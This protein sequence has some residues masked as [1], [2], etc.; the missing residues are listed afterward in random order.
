MVQPAPPALE[1][2][3][4]PGGPEYWKY[5]PRMAYVLSTLALVVGLVHVWRTMREDDRCMRLTLLRQARLMAAAIQ[6]DDLKKLQG[7][8][9]DLAEPQYHRLKRHIELLQRTQPD[10]HYIY[11]VGHRNN[12]QIFFFL[13]NA[14]AD[15]DDFI[16]PGTLYDEASVNFRLAVTTGKEI[17]EGPLADQWGNWISAVAPI[18]DHSTGRPTAALGVDIDASRW[19][20]QLLHQAMPRAAAVIVIWLFA[21]AAIAM[22]HHRYRQNPH[23]ADQSPT[24]ITALIAILGI[25]IT[26][27]ACRRTYEK[28][29]QE[30]ADA[31][32]RLA[33]SQTGVTAR[34]FHAI[35][36]T[37]LAGLAHFFASRPDIRKDEFNSYI[38][39]LEGKP[40]VSLWGWSEP[41]PANEREAFAT[42]AKQRGIN[43]ITIWEPGPNREIRPAQKR[44]TFYPVL[45]Y[46]PENGNEYILGADLSSET[47][48]LRAITDATRSRLPTAT[49][50]VG[51][52]FNDRSKG[53]LIFYPVFTPGTTSALRGVAFASINFA[54]LVNRE[55]RR[56]EM[57]HLSLHALN[58]DAIPE[59]LCESGKDPN[60]PDRH[61]LSRPFFA[62]GQV[63]LLNSHPNLSFYQAHPFQR[64]RSILLTGLAL[65]LAIATICNLLLKRRA[66]LIADMHAHT[67][68]LSET[69]LL[70]NQ[71]AEQSRTVQWRC[72]PDGR[73]SEVNPV[74][75]RVFGYSPEQLVGKMS[76]FDLNPEA[77]R[78]TF[79]P[80]MQ[81]VLQQRE[82][83]I[84]I[85]KSVQIADGSVIKVSSSGTPII[86]EDGQLT[87]F[88]GW[89]RDVTDREELA[90]KLLQSQRAAEAANQAKSRFIT[91][92][93][94]EIRT[95]INGVIGFSDLLRST[96][97]NN[98]QR[99]YVDVIGSSSCQLLGLVNELLDYAQLD[100]GG[101]KIVHHD[102][103]LRIT[104]EDLCCQLAVNAHQKNLELLCVIPP[105]LSLLLHGDELHLQQAILCLLDNAVKFTTE[106]EVV[107][108]V[109][110]DKEDDKHVL[111]RFTVSDSGIGIS[112]ALQ[113]N[114]FDSF[115]QA[116]ESIKRRHGGAGL[117]LAIAKHLIEQMGGALTITSET[118][119]GSVFSFAIP[120]SKQGGGRPKLHPPPP[121]LVHAP[122]LVVDDN[123][124]ACQYLQD[125]LAYKALQPHGSSE[126]ASAMSMLQ[127]ARDARRPFSLFFLDLTMPGVDVDCAAALRQAAG[128]STI[129]VGMLPL[130]RRQSHD[131]LLLKHFPNIITKPIRQKDLW[132]GLH[133]AVH[134]T[135]RPPAAD[136]QQAPDSTGQ[137][138]D[139]A[140]PLW[141][142]A[143]DTP[144]P[145]ATILLVEDHPVNQRVALL[146]LEKAGYHADLASNGNEA[147]RFLTQ[148][149]YQLV[150]MDVQ[151]P[152][153]DGLEATRR[154]RDANF[155]AINRDVPII[156]IT[157][158]AIHGYR[159]KCLS[160]GMND[161]LTKPYSAVQL[162]K[163][164]AKWLRQ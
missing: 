21:L 17:T 97:L 133:T 128:S 59:L 78:E 55:F 84:D 25:L 148:K 27:Y 71:L 65:S 93:S 138:A 153:M 160:A 162:R 54:H 51:L 157:A 131:A 7:T 50:P 89:D 115:F 23:Q 114:I 26:A 33:E 63:F 76:I 122:V 47:K 40:P 8:P 75:Q 108:T 127:E 126:L 36:A 116:D 53:M 3:T 30:H 34:K 15:S 105:Q 19:Q 137:A 94:H 139:Q 41:V 32:N 12:G 35:A 48:R 152:E 161:F 125:C 82:P 155:P 135:M 144:S 107:L 136:L 112:P 102:F 70:F 77:G 99:E 124:S 66:K 29:Q 56:S 134:N 159:E 156:A 4:A 61:A 64:V 37:E 5:L 72:S 150:L 151:M 129:F 52:G 38:R 86:D 149:G 147:L 80:F 24:L 158:H 69:K 6:P 85:I 119:C 83:F 163:L 43:T 10:F 98:E 49:G 62:F 104:I 111:A 130:G 1:Q 145:E 42:R 123:A 31:F 88:Y 14:P 140:E 18:F 118:A 57:L 117:G 67:S 164:V 13:N 58:D 95:P 20:Q 109:S 44:D 106:G 9:A 103:N 110:I 100:A 154:I 141:L 91:N 146:I 68:A 96:P 113:Q 81:S 143:A 73:F 16:T 74:A 101:I 39:Y 142:D 90:A 92:M 87:G 22:V 11:L 132:H 60:C 121:E 45:F 46:A 2:T 28:E 120:L 79:T